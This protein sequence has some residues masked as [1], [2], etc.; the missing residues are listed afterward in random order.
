M[1]QSGRAI[2]HFGPWRFWVRAIIRSIRPPQRDEE[3]VYSALLQDES[4]RLVGDLR[5]FGSAAA[6]N[7]PR[8][9]LL[10]IRAITDN[11]PPGQY[12]NC[13]DNPDVHV[14]VRCAAG[15]AREY[16]EAEPELLECS[17]LVSDPEDDAVAIRVDSDR[18]FHFEDAGWHSLSLFVYLTDVS[19]ESGAREVVTGS[20]ETMRLWDLIRG[21]IPEDEIRNRYGDQIRTIVGPSGT[22]FFEDTTAIHRRRLYKRRSVILHVLFVSHRCWASGGRRLLNYSDYLQD[23]LEL[24]H[25]YR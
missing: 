17:L 25:G 15:V 6:G 20:H 18:H 11:L 5:Q 12:G 23:H 21:I 24:T 4:G 22:M 8:D 13:Q 2:I 14:L 3:K 9:M 19:D 7:L 1:V 16:L 10:R